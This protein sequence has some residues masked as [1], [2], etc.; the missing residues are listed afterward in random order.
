[1]ILIH[2]SNEVFQLMF[3]VVLIKDRTKRRALKASQGEP[4]ATSASRRMDG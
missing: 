2:P 4:T 3:K 1:M